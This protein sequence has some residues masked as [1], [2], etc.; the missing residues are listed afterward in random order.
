MIRHSH[1]FIALIAFSLAG[2]NCNCGGPNGKDGGN[3]G[4][5]TGG[6]NS[7]GGN[8][9]GGDG[10]TAGGSGGGTGGAG[11]GAFDAGDGTVTIVIPPGG[12][13]LDGGSTDGG[14]TE[15]GSGVKLDPNG[16]VVLN[17]GS[18]EFYFMWI[19][20]DAQGWVSKYD[21][22]TGKEVGRYWSVVPRD[23]FSAAGQPKGLPC[24]G[25]RDNLLRGNMA[26]HP[27]RTALDLNGDV[28]VANRALSIQ[29]SVT[30]I[31]ND[32]SGC[33]DRN[34]NGTIETSKD[35][36]N[37]GQIT[38]AEMITPTD[39]ANP[40][41]YDECVVFS[42]PIGSPTGDVGV[43]ALA[44]SLGGIESTNGYVWAGVYRDKTFHKLDTSNGQPVAVNA[45]GDMTVALAFGPYGAIVDSKQR[46][47]AVY[48]GAAWLAL[49]DTT[50]GA[51]V[52]DQIKPPAATICGAYALG[53]DGKDRVWLAG[54]TNG[55]V[56]CRYDHAT[57]TW[58][59][60][61]FQAAVSQIGTPFGR[62]R[63]IAADDKGNVFMSA[64]NNSA[65]AAAQLIRFDAETG[66][67]SKFGNADFIDATD[68]NTNTS[69]G[70]GLDGD[71][72]P[73]V[74]NSSGNV[75]KI[76]KVTGGITRTAQQ[77]GGLYTY[78]DFTGYQLRK[79]TA[80]RGTYSKDFKGCST[81]AQWRQIIWDADVPANTTVQVYVRVANLMA[82][83][84]T[85]MR[86]GPFTTSP[87]D[88]L[89]AMVP[90]AQYIR[91]EFVL[92]STDGMTTPV[93][94]SFRIVSA[95]A[96]VIN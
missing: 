50:T 22:R 37:D 58:T 68:G 85:A 1:F 96:G 11:G 70:V 46:L 65:G 69:I 5:G 9:G 42:T 76:D 75:M 87:A 91:V 24:T 80:P 7:D 29:G 95:C 21:T 17:S 90:K 34:A 35:L 56:A 74:N 2:C 78:S 14:P 79:F 39:W 86:Y 83:L 60:F 47:F 59:S 36:D 63:G 8:T 20:N 88:L 81:D 25:A 64:D 28:W 15:V 6:S 38:G 51:L 13:T 33:I 55:S 26:N 71:G 52:S 67:I 27:S 10:G 31:A 45:A 3:T 12:F 61:D 16:F 18:T 41:Q 77:P 62:P 44:V 19:A 84:P 94:K 32:A 30:K 73:W 72:H 49:I 48:P 54:W 66:A 57:A 82:D 43:R 4:G 89:G 93:L 23:C 40:L 92:S 53:I